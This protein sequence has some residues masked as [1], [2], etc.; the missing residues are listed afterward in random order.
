VRVAA[1]GA[2]VRFSD[3]GGAGL[4]ACA[5]HDVVIAVERH[6]LPLPGTIEAAARLAAAD[7]T[8][9]VAAKILRADGALEAAGGTVFSDRSVALIGGSS[10][11]VRAPWHDYVRPVCWAPGLVAAASSLWASARAPEALPDRAF[12]RE[13]CAAV[14]AQG[15]SVVY[16]PTVA[17]VR[18]A[19]DGT[20]PS[21]ALRESSWQRVLDLRPARPRE[22]SDGAWR[23]LLAHDD[24]EA[25]RA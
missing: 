13:W 19:G 18:V 25:C 20:E 12:L 24:T 15:G 21:M 17:A 8:A 11:D 22:L 2:D 6:V 4:S 16:H 3:L 9:A 1:A 23:Y 10:T 14:W 7:P 5:D